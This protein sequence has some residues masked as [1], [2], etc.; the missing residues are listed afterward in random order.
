MSCLSR[1]TAM[2]QYFSSISIPMARRP[3]CF[4][5]TSVVPLPMKGSRMDRAS[6]NWLK[7][8]V[9]SEEHTSELQS[10]P[11]RRSSDLFNTNGAATQLLCGYQRG[12]A[13][14]ERVEDGPCFREL[15]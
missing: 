4:A 5:A 13:A 15:A 14:H 8:H 2:A 7:H 9:R 10:L 6:G 1:S 11:T 3:S 12:S